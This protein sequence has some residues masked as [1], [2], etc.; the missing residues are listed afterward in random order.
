MY[1]TIYRFVLHAC[2]AGVVSAI[3]GRV[4]LFM[5]MQRKY[6]YLSHKNETFH[7]KS[8]VI[9]VGLYNIVFHVE[10]FLL[11]LIPICSYV[12]HICDNWHHCWSI[13]RMSINQLLN[14]VAH[15]DKQTSATEQTTRRSNLKM[16]VCAD[17][18][19]S[20]FKSTISRFMGRN[21]KGNRSA[22]HPQRKIFRYKATPLNVNF[23]DFSN[24]TPLNPRHI[25]YQS[26]GKWLCEVMK[27]LCIS[28]N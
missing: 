16:S 23:A 20:H 6:L 17:T 15:H 14:H 4:F 8:Y 21:R 1:S 13:T 12:C 2:D 25:V 26:E 24:K 7:I 9:Y 5:V 11:L 27:L 10:W 18:C 19:V 22:R 28:Q 3:S